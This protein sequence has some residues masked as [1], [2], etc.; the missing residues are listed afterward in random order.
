MIVEDGILRIFGFKLLFIL[1]WQNVLLATPVVQ[2]RF[3][4][5]VEMNLGE[6]VEV[7]LKKDQSIKLK[8][9]KLQEDRDSLRHALRS[10][11]ATIEINGQQFSV[12]CEN[13]T[14]AKSIE[15][16]EIDVECMATKGLMQ[17]PMHDGWA[18]A[19]D[20]R[21]RIH[22][23]YENYFSANEFIYPLERPIFSGDTQL[24][25]EPTFVDG[26]EVI[27]EE[28]I[29]YHYGVD[30]GGMEGLDTVSATTDG[31]IVAA[32]KSSLKDHEKTS[33][34]DI[35]EDRVTLLDK[36]GWYH[37]Y[38]HLKKINSNIRPGKKIRAGEN[39]GLLGKEGNSGGWAHLH[40][41]IK[42]KMPEGMWASL[43]AYPFLWEASRRKFK[44]RVAAM[45][46]PHR[47]A[48]VSEEVYLHGWFSYSNVH[49][50]KK[51][52]WIFPNGEVKTGVDVQTTFSSPGIYTVILKAE[53]LKG[54]VDY[55]FAKVQIVDPAAKN[56]KY[57]TLHAAHHMG[58]GPFVK[59]KVRI[60]NGQ[61]GD[62][63]I[64]FGDG[65]PPA[66]I[67]LDREMVM[68]GYIDIDHQYRKSGKFLVAFDYRDKNISGINSGRTF[69]DVEV[70][71]VPS[72]R[73][74]RSSPFG[75]HNQ[76]KLKKGK[77]IADLILR[78]PKQIASISPSEF[79]YA[80]DEMR[81]MIEGIAR[82]NE[83]T[84]ILIGD[85]SKR[86]GGRIAQHVAHQRGLDVDIA[87]IPEK[88]GQTGHRVEKFHNRF[89]ENFL[90]SQGL[91][92]NFS[93]K[94]N[95]RLFAYLTRHFEIRTIWVN[96]IIYESMMIYR[97]SSVPEDDQEL[98]RSLLNFDQSHADHFHVRLSCPMDTKACDD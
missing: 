32:G 34:V 81:E 43:N 3:P 69:L 59:F 63:K 68:G 78:Y 55:D 36:R 53:D 1:C 2:T 91:N 73:P 60:F 54:R 50:F 97:P 27:G 93:L 30:L 74:S 24:G 15:E 86:E 25:N 79:Q 88:I 80:T 62:L 19:K 87:Y 9:V 6:T 23:L 51:Y 22:P 45:A 61:E 77:S 48:M 18:L 29:Y 83:G 40:Y 44:T 85:I 75:T 14:L 65:S 20:V 28:R 58:D 98:V 71:N 76:G 21:L 47:L 35:S 90:G 37:I 5:I 17:N 66:G 46:R 11:K 67:P 56:L 89:P 39:I 33:V 84:P 12:Y 96:K 64:D 52:E 49:H 13:Y 57:P 16:Y 38:A 41:D 26:G 72:A 42:A 92:S 95:F 82:W 31:L 4:L 8:L 7:N 94:E 70:L 10:A